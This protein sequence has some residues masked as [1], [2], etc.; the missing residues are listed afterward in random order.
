MTFDYPYAGLILPDA[1]DLSPVPYLN[2]AAEVLADLDPR[3]DKHSTTLHKDGRVWGATLGIIVISEDQSVYG[4]RVTLEVVTIDGSP[5]D[6]Q[7]AAQ[8]LSA[9]VRRALEHSSADILEWYAP[10]VLID[11]DDFLRLRGLVSPRD[12]ATLSADA[13]SAQGIC[14][15]LYPEEQSQP[16]PDCAMRPVDDIDQQPRFG[17]LARVVALSRRRFAPMAAATGLIAGL[18]FTGQMGM[19]YAPFLP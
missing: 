4:P 5:P 19:L 7:E 12:I 15:T 9:T 8:L 11:R 14:G 16:N 18:A 2:S 1:R 6:D 17:L 13:D 10:D 3:R